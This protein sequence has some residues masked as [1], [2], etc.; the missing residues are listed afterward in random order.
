VLG[1]IQSVTKEAARNLDNL[2]F[3]AVQFPHI[4]VDCSCRFYC[5]SMERIGM[6]TKREELEWK[7]DQIEQCFQS[8][9]LAVR[10]TGGIVLPRWVRFNLSLGMGVRLEKVRRLAEDLALALNVDI[11]RVS[12]QAGSVAVEIP[13]TDPQPIRLLPLQRRLRKEKAL[14]FCTAALGLADN[15]APLLVRLTSPQVAHL[16]VVG[17][18][19]S[20]KTSLVRTIIASLAMNHRRSQLN[21]VLIDPKR[22]AFGP[23]AGLPH[24]AHPVV[25]KPDQ[26][27][28]T[29]AR[30][31]KL[32][33]E[34][35]QEN[36]STPHLVVVIDEI[37][38]LFMTNPDARESFTR[39]AQRGREAGIHLVACTQKPTVTV[40][41]SLAK[42]NFPVRLVGQVTSPEEAK[43]ATGYAGT[44]AELL[45]GPG[46]FLAVV[47]GQVT[48][49]DAAYLDARSLAQVV[50]EVGHQVEVGGGCVMLPQLDPAAPERDRY[51]T[52]VEMV[53]DMW[54]SLT[55]KNGELKHGAKADIAHLIFNI[56]STAGGY[57][58][59][60]NEVLKRV[61]ARQQG[62]SSVTLQ[63]AMS[64]FDFQ[65]TN[66]PKTTTTWPAILQRAFGWLERPL[67]VVVVVFYGVKLWSFQWSFPRLW[68]KSRKVYLIRRK[69]TWK[70]EKE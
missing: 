15:G 20:G 39:L 64:T 43:I 63:C 35:D 41:N 66:A 57:G 68:A 48:R 34:R 21:F 30:L 2:P 7:S 61:R 16:L 54:P 62:T 11:C 47:G 14:P 44:K 45:R 33:L 4:W 32:M 69:D 38:D 22:R 70:M 28:E 1:F 59:T 17:T 37:A 23:L 53:E 25:V 12:R 50:A 67:V 13:R 8:H 46:Q 56:R 29:L 9:S 60:V 40:M 5:A 55:K 10:V 3:V 36:I 27:G 65:L 58:V 49:F 24:L 19:G 6:K 42:A 31:V 18:T 26:A 52:W 51:A